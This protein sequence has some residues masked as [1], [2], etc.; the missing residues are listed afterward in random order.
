MFVTMH[1]TTSFSS[2]A[3]TCLQRECNLMVFLSGGRTALACLLLGTRRQV[4]PPTAITCLRCDCNLVMFLS[5][6]RASRS[7]IS[8]GRASCLVQ[9]RLS[10]CVARP[11]VA[12]CATLV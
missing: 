8:V 2:T 9:H 10:V 7:H 4:S 11:M 12:F 3:I 6:D 5:G 1:A